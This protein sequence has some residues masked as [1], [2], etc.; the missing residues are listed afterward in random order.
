MC[1]LTTAMT[2]LKVA[3]AVGSLYTQ[4]QQQQQQERYNQQVYDNQMQAYRMNQANSNFDRVQ[5]AENLATTKVSNDAAARRARA[6]AVT[7]AGESGVS[8]LSVD[9]LLS[10]LSGMSGRDN[11]NAEVNYLRRD[12]AI[13]ADA[14]NNYANTASAINKLETPKAPDYLGSALKIGDAVYEYKNPKVNR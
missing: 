10:E 12:R 4:Q 5:E 3:S 11:V 14:F 6:T 7:A 8:G 2:V 1:E 13:Q 9:A